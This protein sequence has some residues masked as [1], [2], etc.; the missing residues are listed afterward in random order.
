MNL[1]KLVLTT[2]ALE[3]ALKTW[4]TSLL[5]ELILQCENRIITLNIETK[6]DLKK[7]GVDKVLELNINKAK[8]VHFKKMLIRAEKYNNEVTEVFYNQN[9]KE[10][11]D[12]FTDTLV[13]IYGD[14]TVILQE[15]F[16]NAES[17]K[18]SPAILEESERGNIFLNG[19][20]FIIHTK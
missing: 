5:H 10:K 17:K 13:D 11:V 6:E 8:I 16:K 12:K 7:I 4:K 1:E 15:I 18:L 20:K 14:A 3:G 9:D 2:A 19:K